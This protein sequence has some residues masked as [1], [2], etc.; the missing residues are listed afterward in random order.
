MPEPEKKPAAK[1]PRKKPAAAAPQPA[2]PAAPAPEPVP[3]LSPIDQV[4]AKYRLDKDVNLYARGAQNQRMGMG[5]VIDPQVFNKFAEL[6]NTKN[7]RY[8]D[9]MLFQAGGGTEA[10]KKSRENW[11]DGAEELPPDHFFKLF[12]EQKPNHIIYYD[13]IKSV[14]QKL[15]D[16]GLDFP[17]LVTQV[18][19]EIEQ[20]SAIPNIVERY[21]ALVDLLKRNN[22]CPG[23][24]GRVSV[25]LIGNKFK[26]WAKQQLG[27]KTRDRVHAT[28]VYSRLI[29]GIDRQIAEQK[30][31]ETEARRRRDYIFGD[32]DSLKWEAFGFNRHWPGRNNIYETVYNVMREFLSNKE[33]V[34]NYNSRI[35]TYNE[36]IAEKNKTLPP[37]Q[38]VPE[39][40]G[41]RLDT[42]IGKVQADADG[43]I[44]YK[45][46]FPNTHRMTEFNETVANLPLRERIT[47]DVSYA[48]PKGTRSKTGRIYSD[49][50][51]DVVA[52]LTVA[53]A[54]EA[55]NPSWE[56]SNPDQLK[57]I[58][59][60]GNYSLGGWS[61]LATAEHGHAEWE[62][63]PAISV[64]FHLKNRKD[65]DKLWAMIFLDDLVELQPPYVATIW[66]TSG[67]SNGAKMT[68]TQ[69]MKYLQK[70]AHRDRQSKEAYLAMVRSIGNGMKAVREWG[71]EFNPQEI[72]GDYVK[73]HRE[74][75][76]AKR[77]IGESIKIRAAQIV[78]ALLA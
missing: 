59:T 16:K 50:N 15:K 48:G 13:E 67:T 4:R 45:G 64:F 43:N 51:V 46:N 8:L 40:K 62:H 70:T 71:K 63:T 35:D 74:R 75:L 2:A 57:N 23:R 11:G 7:K 39:R 9:W 42:D 18:P 41:I 77:N 54:I 3:A 66:R 69:M 28:S 29:R 24:E 6:D 65:P 33:R 14:T 10:F 31:K 37:E 61:N 76:Q 34:D 22:V 49:A 21:T 58:R 73:H 56:V 1:K 19:D 27:T 72:I 44:T 26:V 38:Q 68:F 12:A 55:G 60:S 53:A 78:E 52:P 47:R 25:E 17:G 32:Q 36:R 5:A 30:W 20:V